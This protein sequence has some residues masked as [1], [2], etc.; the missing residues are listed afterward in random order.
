MMW[1]SDVWFARVVG[2]PT[3]LRFGCWLLWAVQISWSCDFLVFG[4]FQDLR[5]LWVVIWRGR[6]YRV[7]WCFLCADLLF[8]VGLVCWF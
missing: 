5:L 1:V 2:L 4:G 8:A 3:L 6:C 7:A